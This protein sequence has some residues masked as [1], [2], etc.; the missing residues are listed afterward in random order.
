MNFS[1]DI[2]SQLLIEQ[3]NNI[4]TVTINNTK[5]KNALNFNHLLYLMDKMEEAKSDNNIK[6]IFITAVKGDFFTSGND[7]NNF[8]MMTKDE[9]SNGFQKFI[10]Y[11]IDYPKLLAAGIN[12]TCIGMG[13]T[14]L[15]HFD[16][17]LCSPSASFL[18]PFIQTMQVP[19]GTSSYMFPRMFGKLAAHILYKGDPIFAE[20][21]KNFGLVTKVLEENDFRN[22]CMDY[23]ENIT[24]HP[25]RLLVLYKSMIKR[26][27]SNFLKEVNKYEC[28]ELRKSWDNPEFDNVMKKFVKPKF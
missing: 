28:S 21:A 4:L 11:L 6:A 13:F 3:K 7:F 14:M 27:D 16:I 8:A 20:E 1:N 18:V 26:Y 2:K 15:M 12:G 25:L 19:E 5:K 9:M 22:D 23:L 24:K 17:V 10:D